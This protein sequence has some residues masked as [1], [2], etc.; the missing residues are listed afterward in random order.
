LRSLARA[1]SRIR[2]V[3]VGELYALVW[4][5]ATM[6]SY[7]LHDHSGVRWL[8]PFGIVFVLTIVTALM[9]LLY[10]WHTLG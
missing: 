3:A 2:E 8:L 9:M 10:P 4:I 1:P 7:D 5:M 6:P